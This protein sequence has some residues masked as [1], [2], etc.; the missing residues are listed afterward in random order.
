MVRTVHG[1]SGTV[2]FGRPPLRY[3]YPGFP[4]H[5]LHQKPYV[6][7]A[8]LLGGRVFPK[9]TSL[10]L[11]FGSVLDSHAVSRKPEMTMSLA[12]CGSYFPDSRTSRYMPYL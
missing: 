9:N 3:E 10:K 1:V 8:L 12:F 6:G 2:P 11:G 4:P 7:H 5:P